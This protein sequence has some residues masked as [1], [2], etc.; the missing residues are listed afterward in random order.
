MYVRI[1]GAKI[2]YSANDSP[3]LYLAVAALAAAAYEY[4]KAFPQ[5][6]IGVP[7]RAKVR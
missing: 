1:D 6:A 2:R 3:S 4:V 7:C 5:K